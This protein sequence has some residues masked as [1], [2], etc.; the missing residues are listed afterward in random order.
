MDGQWLGHVLRTDMAHF[1]KLDANNLVLEVHAVHNNDAPDESTGIAFLQSWSNGYP[2][3]K[4]CSYNAILRKNYPGKGYVYDET[5]DA[6]INPQPYSSW[7]LDEATCQWQ[8][9]IPCPQ[10]DKRYVWDESTLN[11]KGI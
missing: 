9:P 5:R 10:D 11:W 6:F 1:A 2:Y 8:A 4:Q 3:W 7:L